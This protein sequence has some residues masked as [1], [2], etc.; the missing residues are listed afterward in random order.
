MPA[1]GSARA[2]L[3]GA[4]EKLGR[5]ESRIALGIFTKFRNNWQRILAD[6]ARAGAQRW[7]RGEW[8]GAHAKAGAPDV[9]FTSGSYLPCV[10]QTLGV[11]SSPAAYN[12][13]GSTD[14]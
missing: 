10:L 9:D 11:F 7:T 3:R 1:L 4:K 14:D 13:R 6:L 8:A 12:R 5:T 2:H